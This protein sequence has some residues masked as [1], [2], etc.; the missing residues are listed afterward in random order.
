MMKTINARS[1]VNGALGVAEVALVALAAAMALPFVVMVARV[2]SGLVG[3][4]LGAVWV[5]VASLPGCCALIAL[6]VLG[7]LVQRVR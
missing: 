4:V 7:L 5:G 2:A 3:M 1:I 6:A